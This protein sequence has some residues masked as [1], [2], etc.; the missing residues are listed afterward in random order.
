MWF[1]HLNKTLV[2]VLNYITCRSLRQ[3]FELKM[4]VRR[5]IVSAPEVVNERDV[6]VAGEPELTL[7]SGDEEDNSF[8]FSADDE[9]KTAKPAFT[10][11]ETDMEMQMETYENERWWF[12]QGWSEK[13]LP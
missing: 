8:E 3:K 7:Q 13:M 1:V 2:N 4:K 9:P 5:G 6:L 10:T 12:G 11:M